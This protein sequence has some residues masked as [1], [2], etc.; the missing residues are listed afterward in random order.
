MMEL[1]ISAVIK[2][3]IPAVLLYFAVRYAVKGYLD[4]EEKKRKENRE[5]FNLQTAFPLRLQA[6][7][8]LILLMERIMP[9]QVVNRM[10]QP[11]L[12]AFQFQKVLIQGIREEYEHN[13]AQQL[14]ISREGWLLVRAAKEELI[15]LINTTAA[16]AGADSPAGEMAKILLERWA[17]MDENPLQLAI[18]RLKDEA[19][20][21][22]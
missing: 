2:F 17:K 14:Y 15:R 7:E 6:Y 9:P 11:G 16:E 22:F 19:R 8:R 13:V 21:L 3:L 10:I 4:N 20:L 5:S 18:D 1:W 12:S